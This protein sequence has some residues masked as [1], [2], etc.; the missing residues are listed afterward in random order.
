[1]IMSDPQLIAQLNTASLKCNE[2]M[3]RI[4]D[5][6]GSDDPH[7]RKVAKYANEILLA[8][9]QRIVSFWADRLADG[10]LSTPRHERLIILR[11]ILCQIKDGSDHVKVEWDGESH[12]IEYTMGECHP[13]LGPIINLPVRTINPPYTQGKFDKAL[14]LESNEEER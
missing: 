13:P 7:I 9:V 8:E 3:E 10:S 14:A 6:C 11:Q 1:M 4:A 12:Q 5:L 2:A